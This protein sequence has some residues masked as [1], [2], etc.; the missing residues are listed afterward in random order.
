MGRIDPNAGGVACAL[1]V[2]G[3][4][5]LALSLKAAPAAGEAK[6]GEKKEAAAAPKVEKKEPE[7]KK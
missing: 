1:G 2:V 4:A 3:M 7:K 6:P 5:I